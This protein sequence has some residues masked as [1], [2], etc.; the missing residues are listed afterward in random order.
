MSLGGLPSSFFNVE[1]LITVKHKSLCVTKCYAKQSDAYRFI[2]R[3]YFL[4]GT[5]TPVQ[6]AVRKV[7]DS[8]IL[9][10]TL[11]LSHDEDYRWQETD[12]KTCA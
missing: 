4:L 10:A 2:F 1:I 7:R 5:E 3:Q 8:F 12:H 9:P 11:D 6:S